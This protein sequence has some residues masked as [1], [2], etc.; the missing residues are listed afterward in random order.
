M[1]IRPTNGVHQNEKRGA[2]GAQNLWDGTLFG[3]GYGGTVERA[4]DG[5]VH[6]V[7]LY[8]PGLAAPSVTAKDER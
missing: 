2:V 3:D 5:S 6:G 8:R 1:N 4:E 7:G